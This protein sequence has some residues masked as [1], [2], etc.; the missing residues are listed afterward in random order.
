MDGK[1]KAASTISRTVAIKRRRYSFRAIDKSGGMAVGVD[2][3]CINDRMA[4]DHAW[5]MVA[6]ARFPAVQVWHRDALVG[7]LE[8]RISE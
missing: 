8:R 4:I 5:N 2:C 6:M 3:A 1:R 7:V